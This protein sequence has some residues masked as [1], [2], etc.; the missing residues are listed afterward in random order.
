MICYNI[1][2]GVKKAENFEFVY[3]PYL[4]LRLMVLQYY[5]SRTFSAK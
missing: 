1:S 3:N 2:R 4:I 5:N